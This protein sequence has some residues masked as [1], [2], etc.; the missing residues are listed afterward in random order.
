MRRRAL[1]GCAALAA[2]L[3]PGHVA[4]AQD[5]VSQA[6]V[7]PLPAPGV[8]K[9]NDALRALAVNSRNVNALIDAGNAS[10]ELGDIEAAIGFFGRANELSPDNPRVKMGLAGAYVRTERPIEA[11]RLFD[12]AEAAGIATGMLAAERGLAFDLVGDNAS[13]QRYYQQA[14]AQRDDPETRRRFALSH[15]IAGDRAAA[16]QVLAP[17]LQ[18]QDFA[19]YRTQAFAKAIIGEEGEAIAIAEAV[20]PRDLSARITPYLRY[21]PRLTRAQQAAA[22]NLGL[23]PRA[24]QIGRDDPRIAQFSG[25][26]DAVRNSDAQLAPQGEPMGPATEPAATP[27]TRTASRRNSSR[28]RQRRATRENARSTRRPVRTASRPVVQELPQVPTTVSEPVVQEIPSAAATR[29]ATP[30]VAASGS[31]AVPARATT[32]EELPEVRQAPVQVVSNEV[33]QPTI[34]LAQADANTPESEEASSPDS[35]Q[36]ASQSAPASVADAFSTFDLSE[37]SPRP[38]PGRGVD[39]RSID[40]PREVEKPP[41]KAEPEPPRHPRRFWVQVAT[42]QNVSALK[43]DWR[44][45][46]RKADGKL[47]DFSPHVTPWGQ[48]NRLLAGPYQS[49][50]AARK[51]MNSLKESDIDSF[52]FTS[53][54]GQEIEQLD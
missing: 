43:F 2:T 25:R 32:T 46:A 17:L 42:G 30:A 11:L 20:M 48:S 28:D 37:I 40:P 6:V 16:E 15:A 4:T 5:S 7:Q 38:E 8:A 23:F 19:A 21:M 3:H 50:D 51:A 26:S 36:A 27:V 22:A 35:T 31:Q 33:A 13:A 29:T 53:P 45:I 18:K 47:D 10:L 54:E 44:R 49:A 39:I 41:E 9:L 52:T 24:A 12:E 1:L 14:L 34:D